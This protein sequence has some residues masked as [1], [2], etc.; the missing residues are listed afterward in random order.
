MVKNHCSVLLNNEELPQLYNKTSSDALCVF[1]LVSLTTIC[2]IVLNF[3][4]PFGFIFI[5]S[6]AHLTE[7]VTILD[8]LLCFVSSTVVVVLC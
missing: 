7:N 5:W 2:P 4:K 3:T 1:H 8:E 6:E